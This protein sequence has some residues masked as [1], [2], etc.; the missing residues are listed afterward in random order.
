MQ[1][2]TREP[3][4]PGRSLL[5]DF[6]ALD[7]HTPDGYRAELI[8]GAITVTPPPGGNHE[9]WISRIVRQINRKSAQ[10]MDFSGNKGLTV[11]S[12]GQED[13]GHVIP[14]VI[15]AP[16]SLD[17]F[18][19]APSWMRPDGVEMVVEVTS[20]RPETDRG[21]KRWAYAAAGIP[22]YLLVDRGAKQ[23]TLLTNP[24]GGDYRRMSMVSFGGS[25]ELPEPFGFKLDTSDFA[26]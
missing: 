3:D 7:A 20:S 21:A 2:M 8:D 5:E 24:D 22:L 15:F 1:T 17:L 9:R 26:V 6:L 4:A 13:L 10:E 14:D 11:P 16:A 25:I 19:D 23:V 18:R 12:D